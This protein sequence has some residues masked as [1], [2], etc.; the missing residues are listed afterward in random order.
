MNSVS[1]EAERPASKPTA[2][3][4]NTA[5]RQFPVADANFAK[6]IQIVIIEHESFCTV[7]SKFRSFSIRGNPIKMAEVTFLPRDWYKFPNPARLWQ[8]RFFRAPGSVSAF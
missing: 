8:K 1:V 3:F 2:A 5:S 7:Q 4:V 6:N